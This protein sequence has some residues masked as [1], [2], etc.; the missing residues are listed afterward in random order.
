MVC[1]RGL[2]RKPVDSPL[3]QVQS[4]HVLSCGQLAPSVLSYSP[5][6]AA[7]LLMDFT[8]RY[9]DQEVMVARLPTRP[10]AAPRRRHCSLAMG[11]VRALAK[12]L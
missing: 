6:Q 11:C 4:A 12:N 9:S 2:V 5:I 3:Y 7:P 1:P 8:H 10:T